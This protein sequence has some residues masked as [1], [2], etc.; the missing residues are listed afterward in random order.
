MFAIVKV[1]D[2]YLGPCGGN[3]IL[4][5]GYPYNVNGFYDMSYFDFASNCGAINVNNESFGG[6]Y[7]DN[8]PLG[9]NAG[10]RC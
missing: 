1:N 10:A 2:F 8:I 6:G 9:A 7:G 5:K 3:Q 4:S